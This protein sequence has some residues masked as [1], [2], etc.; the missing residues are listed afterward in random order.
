M[1]GVVP[2]GVYLVERGGGVGSDQRLLYKRQKP[3]RETPTHRGTKLCPHDHP[4][5]KEMEG[6]GCRIDFAM[7][8][9]PKGSNSIPVCILLQSCFILF[10]ELKQLTLP[11]RRQ[12]LSHVPPGCRICLSLHLVFPV[13]CPENSKPRGLHRTTD[14]DI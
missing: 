3:R 12:T 8:R 5:R 2:V 13:P 10:S 1:G 6:G 11:P 7:D 14:P 9:Y 4:I